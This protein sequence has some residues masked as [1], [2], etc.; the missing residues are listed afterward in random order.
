MWNIWERNFNGE[1]FLQFKDTEDENMAR[2][3]RN[4]TRHRYERYFV[5]AQYLKK[6]RRETLY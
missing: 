3:G 2:T 1:F 4:L 5:C 6:I